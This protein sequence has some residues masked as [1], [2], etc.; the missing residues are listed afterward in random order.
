[1]IFAGLMSAFLVSSQDAYWVVFRPSEF[2]FWGL[3]VLLLS[4]GAFAWAVYAIKRSSLRF[5]SVLLNLTLL[6]GGLFAYFQYLGYLDLQVRGLAFTTPIVRPSEDI[7]LRGQLLPHSSA[8]DSLHLRYSYVD[9]SLYAPEEAGGGRLSQPM[10]A[11]YRLLELQG[12][13]IQERLGLPTLNLIFEE[14]FFYS[15]NDQDRQFPLNE[16]A[17]SYA[18]LIL[19]KGNYGSDF[20]L[21]KQSTVLV[22]YGANFYEPSDQF[23]EHP[24]N[25]KIASFKNNASAYLVVMVV[26]HLLHLLV[27]ALALIYLIVQLTRGRYNA[28]SYAG[29]WAVS[30]FWHFLGVL[31][32]VLFS[33]LF[34]NYYLLT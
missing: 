27:A 10:M 28:K 4:S 30:I 2:F 5:A 34:Y 7:W 12:F 13:Y 3:F 16:F 6:F 32:L 31:W 15:P 11:N 23:L 8:M 29:I 14:G 18:G 22:Q 21:K 26:M 9:K 24:L 33:F 25:D 20:V 19:L 17:L 1:M